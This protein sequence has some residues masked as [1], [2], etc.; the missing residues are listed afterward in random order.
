MRLGLD[1]TWSEELDAAGF[2]GLHDTLKMPLLPGRASDPPQK[3][4]S[5]P[6]PRLSPGSGGHDF[7]DGNSVGIGNV[8]K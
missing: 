4:G 2:R 8:Q 6:K 3:H 1:S 5:L 7:R